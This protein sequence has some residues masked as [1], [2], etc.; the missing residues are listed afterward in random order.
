MSFAA[1]DDADLAATPGSP[2]YEHPLIR[3]HSG[4]LVD[5]WSLC[6]ADVR[7]DDIA[8]ALSNECRYAGHAG[9]YS[10]GQHSMLVSGYFHD[11]WLQLAGLLHD[12]EEAYLKDMPSP[13]K[14]RPE[15][16]EY[17]AAGKRVRSTIWGVFGLG[18]RHDI[19]EQTVK[20]IDNEVYFRERASFSGHLHGQKCIVPWPSGRAYRPFKLKAVSLLTTLGVKYV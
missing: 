7:L 2:L 8:F 10:V 20:V 19:L 4:L 12:A 13:I 16:A 15:M 14:A 17:K 5:A 6:A 11:P 9:F 1:I 3:T 18:D